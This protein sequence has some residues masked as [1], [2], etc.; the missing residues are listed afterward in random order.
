MSNKFTLM[1]RI[2]TFTVALA[3]LSPLYAM[4]VPSCSSLQND[5]NTEAAKTGEPHCNAFTNHNARHWCMASWMAHRHAEKAC[6]VGC[7][8][9]TNCTGPCDLGAKK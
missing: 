4:H 6:A 3:A 7:S 5:C 8:Y 9:E 2:A 1:M